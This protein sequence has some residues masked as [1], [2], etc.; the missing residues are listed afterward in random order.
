MSLTDTI[1]NT[2]KQK[3]NI[4]IVASNIDNKLVELGG[5]RATDLADVVNK[6]ENAVTQRKKVAIIE[7][8]DSNIF[9]HEYPGGVDDHDTKTF[10]VAT[11]NLDFVPSKVYVQNYV[12]PLQNFKDDTGLGLCEPNK[13]YKVRS[14]AGYS[15][16]KFKTDRNDLILTSSMY[17]DNAYCVFNFIVPRVI[18]IE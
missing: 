17:I 12:K 16:Y 6:I 13:S 9:N 4:K 10:K 11:L 18:C 1:N 7:L 3:E 15:T 5:Q 8:G 2:N 14:I